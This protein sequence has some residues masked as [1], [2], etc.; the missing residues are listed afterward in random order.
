[1]N[2]IVIALTVVGVALGT[3][4]AASQQLYRWVDDKGR[5]EYRDTPPP[6]A[7]KKVERRR[8]GGSSIETST[9]PYNVQQAT[10]NFP[11]TLWNTACGAPCTQAREHL[12]R[13][14]VPYTEKDPQA[15]MDAFKELTGGLEVPVLYVG[16]TRLKGYVES[17]WD[18]AL[19]IAGYPR[20]APPGFKPQ[21]KSPVAAPKGPLPPVKLYTHPECG[22]PCA[23]ARELLA[24]RDIRFQEVAVSGQPQ[25]DEL[26]KMSGDTRV[27]VLVVGE[28]VTRG[29]AAPEYND[30]L[31]SAGF[32]RTR[33]AGKP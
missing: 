21:Q 28:G 17:D 16:K 18:A 23:A 20:T 14:G 8:V 31:D 29:F 2:R 5:V 30:V 24:G 33:P 7:A 6:S 19:D 3:S 15:N 12:S 11:V 1:M 4:A 9:P 25:I 10:R 22:T 13:R 27:P 26:H 32:P